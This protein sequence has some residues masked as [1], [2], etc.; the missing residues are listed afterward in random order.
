M[1]IILHIGAHKTASTHLQLAMARAREA[2]AL[3]GVALLGPDEL[4]RRG[5]GVPEYLSLQP[6]DPGLEAHG[7]RIKAALGLP[8]ERMVISDENILG[9]AHNVE[10]I[11]TARFYDRAVDRVTRLAA[12][13]PDAPMTIALSIRDP[14]GFL[15][16]AYSQR[17]MSGKLEAFTRYRDGLDPAALRWSDLI[18]RLQGVLPATSWL[19]WRFEDY[20]DNAPAVLKAMLGDAAGLVRLGEGVAHPGLSRAAHAAL[21][22]EASILAE[23]GE[24]AAMKRAAALR[25]AFPKGRQYPAFQPFDAPMLERSAAAYARDQ[26]VIAALPRVQALWS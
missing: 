2:L 16:S 7:A 15:V 6:D 22:A 3:R 8:A 19:V 18:G 23:Q 10:L 5:L 17:L 24:G 1:Q 11:R 26:A 14:A 9:N 25:A 12:L 21:M 20:P 4:R 13:L